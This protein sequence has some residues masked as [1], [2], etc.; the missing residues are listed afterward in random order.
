MLV[1]KGVDPIDPDESKPY[2]H[3][4]TDQLEAGDTVASVVYSVVVNT[5]S[6]ATPNA[7]L[8]GSP[9]IASDGLSTSHQISGATAGVTY[10]V[11][12]KATTTRGDVIELSGLLRCVARG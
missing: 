10:E 4:F 3:D 12:A 8:D 1:Q 5:G 7:I 11:I 9:V 6:D 2:T